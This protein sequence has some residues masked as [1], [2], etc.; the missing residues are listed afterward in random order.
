VTL[1]TSIT[2]AW[3]DDAGKGDCKDYAVAKRSRLLDKGWP[4]S[5]LLLAEAVVTSGEHHAVL[6]VATDSG[7]FVLDNLR[8]GLVRWDVL[9]YRW[10][11]IMSSQ[12]PQDWRKIAR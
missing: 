2:R 3:R 7:D 11:R 5:A 9:P 8:Y 6:V 1:D 10:V 12:N 4:P